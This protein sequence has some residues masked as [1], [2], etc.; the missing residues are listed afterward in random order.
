[1]GIR[2]HKILGYGLNDIEYSNDKVTDKRINV[3]ALKDCREKSFIEWFN[4]QDIKLLAYT[5]SRLFKLDY[6]NLYFNFRLTSF[7]NNKN[8][9][10]RYRVLT[11]DDEF[12]FDNVMLITPPDQ[13]NWYRYDD[14]IDW[15][16]ESFEPRVVD[17][18]KDGKT[19]IYPYEG[20]VG[21]NPFLKTPSAFNDKTT[22]SGGEYNRFVGKWDTK[23]DPIATGEAL[24]DLLNNWKPALPPIIFAYLV[25]S[26]ILTHPKYAYDLR[27][28]LYVYWS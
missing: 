2:V 18:F 23:I 20:R 8:L 19:G 25:F 28:L 4:D 12:G 17:L 26:N 22:I 6:K 10:S 27:P 5:I 11:Y 13:K 9:L 24:D 15:I 21:R 16:E 7:E 3:E 1:M 14:I